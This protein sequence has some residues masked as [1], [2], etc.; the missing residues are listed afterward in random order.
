MDEDRLHAERSGEERYVLVVRTTSARVDWL[1]ERRE[2]V[3]AQLIARCEG[4]EDWL[5]QID[6]RDGDVD[7]DDLFVVSLRH[8]LLICYCSKA[9][10]VYCD[11]AR[12]G[13][14]G[15]LRVLS[16]LATGAWTTVHRLPTPS[17]F[18]TSLACIS[19][20]CR[21]CP[22]PI[23]REFWSRR[24]EWG[25]VS[26]SPLSAC[27]H[28]P[29]LTGAWDV[30]PGTHPVEVIRDVLLRVSSP[31]KR[32]GSR[33][34]VMSALPFEST[35]QIENH[36]GVMTYYFDPSAPPSVED[37]RMTLRRSRDQVL[38]SRFLLGLLTVRGGASSRFAGRL[39]TCLLPDARS[40]RSCVDVILTF[41]SIGLG[42]DPPVSGVE[43]FSVHTGK[44]PCF[45]S[46]RQK[47]Y[48][49]CAYDK[50]VGRAHVTATINASSLPDQMRACEA[51]WASQ[52][53]FGRGCGAWSAPH[54]EGKKKGAAEGGS[55]TANSCRTRPPASPSH[56]RSR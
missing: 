42:N 37:L 44:E 35:E 34:C 43:L 10:Y 38:T 14:L 24:D 16:W 27:R 21:G 54:R 20:L 29:V 31:W 48:V 9:V 33:L 6:R 23:V 41:G 19:V 28:P 3:R 2:A 8:A 13:G 22:V 40:A 47:A 25:A 51:D 39:A 49:V 26:H 4:S 53:L 56:S 7:E 18:Q 45:L 46:T 32:G 11:H 55:P 52:G 50:T 12:F 15:G 30:P 5:S 1:W 36:V 17:A